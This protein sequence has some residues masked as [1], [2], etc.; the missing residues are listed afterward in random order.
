LLAPGLGGFAA[1]L[2]AGRPDLLLLPGLVVLAGFWT[3][4]DNL[5]RTLRRARPWDR[6]ERHFAAALAFL[7]A[8]TATGPVL[9]AGWLRPL[10][11][12]LPAHA[13][14][15]SAHATAAVFGVVLGT[16]L[17]ALSQLVPM[18]T[19]AETTAAGESLD[20]AGSLAFPAGVAALAAGRLLG[21][22]LLAR[23]GGVVAAAT[24]LATA[25]VVAARLRGAR[26]AWTTVHTRYA[27]AALS[28]VAWALATLPAWAVRPLSPATTFGAP[29]A[30]HLL[31]VGGVGFVVLGTLYH[32]VPFVVWVHRYSDRL[33]LESVPAVDDLYDD[34]LAAADVAATAAGTA[35]LV[36]TEA[37]SL[38]A[39]VTVVGGSLLTVGFAAAAANLLLV[40]RRHGEH[41]VR[42]LLL[43]RLAGG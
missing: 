42:W 7:V 25:A 16:I 12:A 9:A 5:A 36:A 39:R 24:I 15:R 1:A 14:L 35:T 27:V 40:V 26:A 22:P 33:G 11:A 21:D 10:P 4:A 8:V 41:S 2:S 28:L 3:F 34:R 18:F 29:A 19:Q 31:L 6:T 13:A 20:R 38:P 43:G 17:G 23:A 32:V 30:T 37:A